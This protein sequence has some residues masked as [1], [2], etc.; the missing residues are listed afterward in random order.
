MLQMA[1]FLPF[2]WLSHLHLL[3]PF[4]YGWTLRL[5]LYLGYY[6]YCCDKHKSASIFSN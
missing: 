5:F 1:T 2:L 3:N 6:K 4:T